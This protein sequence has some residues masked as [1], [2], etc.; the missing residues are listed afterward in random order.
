M[1]FNKIQVINIKFGYVVIVVNYY[2]K[3][4]MC[5]LLNLL[6]NFYSDRYQDQNK[7][8]DVYKDITWSPYDRI[9]FKKVDSFEQFCSNNY[10]DNSLSERKM[11]VSNNKDR[12]EIWNGIKQCMHL[13][14][15]VDSDYNK[16]WNIEPD[17]AQFVFS[18][19]VNKYNFIC[20]YA[21]RFSEIVQRLI[22]KERAFDKKLIREKLY[23]L[24]KSECDKKEKIDFKCFRSLGPEDVVIIFLADS[25]KDI[26]SVVDTINKTTIKLPDKIKVQDVKS[27]LFSTVYAFSSFNNRQYDASTDLDVI[28]RLDLKSCDITE[29]LGELKNHI[30]SENAAYQKIF[31][32]ISALQITIPA[33]DISFKEF[34]ENGIFNGSSEFYSQNIYGSR[35]Y[36]SVELDYTKKDTNIDLSSE[37]GLSVLEKLEGEYSIG[38]GTSPVADFLFGEYRRL[39]EGKRTVQWN[40]ILKAQFDAT[41]SFVKYYSKFDKY[42]ECELLNHMQS[43]LHLI[44]QTCSPVSEIP[45]HNHFYAGSLHDLLKAY[46]G[47]IDMLFE[48]G[49]SIP[50]GKKTTQH[51]ITFA[52]C[53]NSTAFIESKIYTRPDIKNRIVIF[54]LPYDTFWNYSS[55]IKK[56]V[57][58]V[59]H[60]IAP[61]DRETR[62]NSIVNILYSEILKLLLNSIAT[63]TLKYEDIVLEQYISN[64]EYFLIKNYHANVSNKLCN[65]LRLQ[66]PEFFIFPNPE[67]KNLYV[68]KKEILN[69]ILLIENKVKNDITILFEDALEYM[70]KHKENGFESAKNI[71]NSQV[72]N[73]CLKQRNLSISEQS[74][75]DI[76][77]ESYKIDKGIVEK[78]QKYMLAAK[79]AFCDI[80]AIKLTKMNI[81][82][83]IVFLIKSMKDSFNEYIIKVT[84]AKNNSKETDLNFPS[85]IIRIILLVYKHM[86]STNGKNVNDIKLNS[87]FKGL[88]DEKNKEGLFIKQCIEIIA[89]QYAQF[90]N[91][92]GKYVIDDLYNMAFYKVDETFSEINKYDVKKCSEVLMRISKVDLSHNISMDDIDQLTGFLG[93]QKIDNSKFTLN[94]K[95]IIKRVDINFGMSYP[96]IVSN[97]GELIDSIKAIS[98]M[99][100]QE[101]KNKHRLWYRG[102]CSSDFSLLPSIFRNGD[103][104]LSIY[105][106]QAS[107]IKNAY[108]NAPYATDVWNLPIEQ[109]TACLQHYGIPTNLLDFSLDPL[110]SLHF[111]IVPDRPIDRMKIESG[112]FQPVVYVFDPMAYSRAVRRMKEGKP[113]LIIPETISSVTFDINKNEEEKANYFVNDMSYNYLYEHNSKHGEEYVPNDRIDLYPA[114]IV[115]QQTNPRIVAQCGTFVAYS[116]HA[117]PQTQN[118]DQRYEYLNLLKIQERYLEFLNTSKNQ[119]DRFIF[120]IYLKK[121]YVSDIG[122]SLKQLNIRKGKF[123]PELSKI[124]SDVMSDISS[125]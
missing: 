81:S 77:L 87:M 66:F 23:K 93:I 62:A 72:V 108:F 56:L 69:I 63:Q 113:D 38:E 112:E 50:H 94:E 105:A 58:E 49:Y 82:Q 39:L 89:Q 79:E 55:N 30:K 8:R 11:A 125:D 92:L 103:R 19:G 10:S 45:N 74:F 40:S 21:I 119:S 83:Y 36:F 26:I 68:N 97:I 17:D 29:I 53:L 73:E 35:T 124:F 78:L 117:R 101:S 33:G 18:T 14:E 52:I 3:I 91:I 85:T 90:V 75:I 51:P 1:T 2:S 13:I 60:Y 43:A 61:Y 31:S 4:R 114:P 110:A 46:Y 42:I 48:I 67:W 100:S 111:A 32:G 80:W 37:Y 27:N 70:D 47:I 102:V 6:I 9:S 44:N 54:F 116:L 15:D 24:I 118:R 25:M 65:D 28:V 76:Y 22:F 57:H 95:R 64:W 41:K 109:R 59:F 104:T 96:R 120:P 5:I 107:M 16:E 34:Q 20:I 106:N 123:Y 122:N 71:F 12:D 88:Y 7:N 99:V 98:N 115:V 86:K 84:L 121:E